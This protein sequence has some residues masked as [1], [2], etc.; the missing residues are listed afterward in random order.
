MNIQDIMNNTRYNTYMH[1]HY[2]N[3][4]KMLVIKDFTKTKTFGRELTALDII[5]SS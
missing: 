1:T 5:K 4:M 2:I 3:C